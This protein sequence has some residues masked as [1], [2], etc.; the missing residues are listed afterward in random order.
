MNPNDKVTGYRVGV[1]TWEGPETHK[2]ATLSHLPCH[3]LFDLARNESTPMEWRKAA[4]E[5]LLDKRC[6][7]ASHPEL[8][9]LV[10]EVHAERSAELHSTSH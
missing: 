10:S 3:N 5:L 9:E 4:V 7:Q 8:K 6:L 2:E 1:G